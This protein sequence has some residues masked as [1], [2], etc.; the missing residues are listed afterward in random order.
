MH[1]LDYCLYCKYD[2]SNQ[3]WHGKKGEEIKY[4]WCFTKVCYTKPETN[5]LIFQIKSFESSSLQYKPHNEQA[6]GDFWLQGFDKVFVLRPVLHGSILFLSS[7][8]DS[9][10]G[11]LCFRGWW[12]AYPSEL[13]CTS[14]SSDGRPSPWPHHPAL[15]G[16]CWRA[17]SPCWMASF[18]HRRCIWTLTWQRT[19]VTW[20]LHWPFNKMTNTLQ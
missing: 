3:Q 15:S 4:N 18:F 16:A 20:I 19:K 10:G 8:S 6:H 12:W 13:R 17:P 11:C 1:A 9:P 5:I 7:S 2:R 14:C